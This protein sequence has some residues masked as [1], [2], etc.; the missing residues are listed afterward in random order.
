MQRCMN[1]IFLNFRRQHPVTRGAQWLVV[2]LLCLVPAGARA[3]LINSRGLW[4]FE[5]TFASYWTCFVPVTA[6]GL[7]PGTDYSFASSGGYSYLQTQ[8][9][10]TAA[11]RL[12]VVNNS[13]ANGWPGAAARTN[14]WSVVM[15]IRFDALAPYAGI[16]QMDPAN[17]G[18][19]SFYVIGANGTLAGGLGTLSAANAIAANTWYRIALTCG[20]NGAGGALTLKAYINGALT[21]T[22]TSPFD[23]AY[24]MRPTFLMLSDN[25]GELKPAKLNS[26]GLWGEELSATDIA[27]LAG[28]RTYGL[29]WPG[30]SDANCP[31]LAAGPRA[32]LVGQNL[33]ITFS[34]PSPTP[35]DRLA[36]FLDGDVLSA[37]T[38]KR[39]I[40]IGGGASPTTAPPGGMPVMSTAGLPA[41]RYWLHYLPGDTYISAHRIAIRLDATAP[42]ISISPAGGTY[43]GGVVSISGA[44]EPGSPGARI[45]LKEGAKELPIYAGP[46]DPWGQFTIDAVP[47]PR[48]AP[49][50][51][52]QIFVIPT[53]TTE[54][55]KQAASFTVNP[56]PLAT[57]YARVM[58]FPPTGQ[59]AL[60]PLSGVTVYAYFA[61]GDLAGTA[62]TGADGRCSFP[63]QF[64]GTYV[65]STN[66]EGTD[67]IELTVLRGEASSATAEFRAPRFTVEPCDPSAE[68][69]NLE[70]ITQ[71]A[72]LFAGY[73][74]VF[75]RLQKV[76][77]HQ[78]RSL[79]LHQRER[80]SARH[81]ASSG[82]PPRRMAGAG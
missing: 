16:L 50:A 17:V 42:V 35:R 32:V 27:S 5:G 64:A 18:D 58:R 2:L 28:P 79:C 39:A 62:L 82:L 4:D 26:L 72:G 78:R 46:V 68:L 41:G 10:T 56:V 48:N 47:I 81:S 22:R 55:G 71:S 59:T 77:R 25:N 43:P 36:L 60:I 74:A 54:P 52:T 13:G 63:N 6:D 34:A 3:A 23:G 65:L 12:T 66:E 61:D 29:A 49:V 51:N 73:P 20:N 75:H 19:V 7:T 38:M 76:R 31:V 37:G 14:Q 8:P 9:F 11:K 80:G 67:V 1:S 15:D 40:Y 57:L 44:V 45:L 33:N 21:G 30:F 69:T 24:A 70:A 53:G